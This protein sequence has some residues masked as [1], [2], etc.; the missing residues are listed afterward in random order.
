MAEQ[1]VAIGEL[2][3]P[4]GWGH[5]GVVAA[6]KARVAGW[7]AFKWQRVGD[8]SLYTGGV[9]GTKRNGKPKWS[10]PHTSFAVTEAELKAER[11]RYEAETGRCHSCFGRGEEFAKWSKDEGTTYRPCRICN[12]TGRSARVAPAD[13]E[14]RS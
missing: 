5:G 7:T 10:K 12:A 13:G 4:G 11:E 14:V 2:L 8:N 1:V 9:Q 6:R 3:P